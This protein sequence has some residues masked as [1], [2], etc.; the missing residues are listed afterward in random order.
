MSVRVGAGLSDGHVFSVVLVFEFAVAC[1]V[2][3]RSVGNSRY[4]GGKSF[5][6]RGICDG[7][8]AEGQAIL[9]RLPVIRSYSKRG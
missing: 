3:F 9:F 2:Y 7:A 5:V 8:G 6:V 1:S 4:F